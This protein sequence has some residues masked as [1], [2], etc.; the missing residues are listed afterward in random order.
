V[1]EINRFTFS[2][3]VIGQVLKCLPA[4]HDAGQAA[5]AL[6]SRFIQDAVEGQD[7][8]RTATP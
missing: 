6:E 4:N 7:C 3:D 8:N 5:G 1:G 2:T